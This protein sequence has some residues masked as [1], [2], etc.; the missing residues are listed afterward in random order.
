MSREGIFQ[1]CHHAQAKQV[2]FDDA[3]VG[4]VF[5]VPL[6]HHAAR[7][8]RGFERDYGIKLSLADDH[9]AGMLAQM[10]RQILHRFA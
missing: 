10:T 6:H 7:H 5:L 2:H 8:G 1:R 3:Q 9:A 4:A